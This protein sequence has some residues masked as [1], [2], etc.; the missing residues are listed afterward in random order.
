MTRDELDVLWAGAWEP[1]ELA[2]LER[3]TDIGL[4][5]EASVLRALARMGPGAAPIVLVAGDEIDGRES[6]ALPALRAAGARAVGALYRAP[7][8]HRA[9]RAAGLGADCALVV[10]AHPGELTALVR[11]LARRD[12]ARGDAA[13]SAPAATFEPLPERG[14]LETLVGDAAVLHRAVGELERLFGVIVATF[15]RR[16]DAERS[17]LLLLDRA[18]QSLV[19][20]KAEPPREREAFAPIP[21]GSGLAG[22]VAASGR[23]LLVRDDAELERAVDAIPGAARRDGY[24]TPSCLIL[25]LHASEGVAGVVC[26]A[27]KRSGGAFD[28]GDLRALLFLAAQAGQAL[29]NAL[30]LRQMR[31]LAV[32]DE[33]T[34]LYNRR[35]FQAAL[36]REV[37]RARRYDRP[38]TL[39]I[40]DLD[41]FKSFNDLCGHPA[42]DR[43]LASVGRILRTS[44]REVDIVARH[45]GEEFAVLLPETSARPGSGAQAPFPF[46]ERLRERVETTE[47]PGEEKLPE[48]RLT[49]SIG[50]ACFPDDAATAEELF[51]RADEALYASKAAGRNRITYCGAAPPPAP[52]GS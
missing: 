9:A 16:A 43:A 47:F 2:E 37:Q 27:D 7:L 11:A 22:T 29:E 5:R 42:G 52:A 36:D 14:T 31:D 50:V 17:S 30:R 26:L 39:A 15:Q 21:L 35:Y 45:G 18:A 3:E 25:P 44:L 41:R 24:R 19:L 32:I 48:K 34:G 23:A 46:L 51:Q 8:A 33:L 13:E 4:R 40:M 20:Q 28:E 6:E 49:I 10:P 1:V 12:A 38:L